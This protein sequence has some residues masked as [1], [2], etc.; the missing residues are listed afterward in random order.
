MGDFQHHQRHGHR[1]ADNGHGEAG[2]TDK[3]RRQHFEVRRRI[4]VI[5]DL[6]I[7]GAQHR[8]EIERGEEHPAA[9][10]EG[11]GQDRG[12]D[13]Q[14]EDQGQG[15]DEGMLLEI[16]LHGAVARGQ[17]LRQGPG[18]RDEAEPA[19]HRPPDLADRQP[20]HQAFHIGHQLDDDDAGAGADHAQQGVE[21]IARQ[22]DIGVRRRRN[23][24]GLGV[25]QG[26]GDHGGQ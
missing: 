21:E 3:G 25:H 9:E 23:D 16:E 6:R 18:Q 8:T 5:D 1:P 22:R 26:G 15:G 14:Q 19:D 7:A 12:A 20:P 17:D 2:H 11:Q 10:A 13:L 4:E 24:E